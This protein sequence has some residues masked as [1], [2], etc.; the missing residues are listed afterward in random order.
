MHTT[1]VTAR[2]IN[3]SLPLGKSLYEFTKRHRWFPRDQLNSDFS[4]ANQH[5]KNSLRRHAN[6][7]ENIC[8]LFLFFF[9]FHTKERKKWK[10]RK[11]SRKLKF[12]W[13][14][15]I[16]DFNR[17]QNTFDDDR[18]SS[19]ILVWVEM[20]RCWWETGAKYR[21]CGSMR[22]WFGEAH[23]ETHR[24]TDFAMLLSSCDM[25]IE[26]ENN[27]HE[28]IAKTIVVRTNGHAIQLSF[29]SSFLS[30]SWA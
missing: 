3:H 20:K 12:I 23:F 15:G 11:F 14:N 28:L 19:Q 17:E 25:W 22:R 16:D 9:D 7:S 21:A 10:K 5:N 4:L 8:F 30:F 2:S 1:D 13:E 26:F 27:L 18:I 24:S 29:S 6:I